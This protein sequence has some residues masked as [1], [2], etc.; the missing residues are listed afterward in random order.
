[1]ASSV[2]ENLIGLWWLLDI[3][4]WNSLLKMAVAPWKV[5]ASYLI[6]KVEK[7]PRKTPGHDCSKHD[8]NRLTH[9]LVSTNPDQDKFNRL[10]A[11]GLDDLIDFVIRRCCREDQ[12][13]MTE[14]QKHAKAEFIREFSSDTT[15]FSQD[16]LVYLMGLLDTIFFAGSLTQ[17]RGGLVEFEMLRYDPWAWHQVEWRLQKPNL[18]AYSDFPSPLSKK[19]LIAM[20]RVS[21]GRHFTRMQMMTILSHEMIH[22]F[23]ALYWDWCPG[24]GRVYVSD[25]VNSH[26]EAF[27]AMCSEINSTID[28]WHP[29]LIDIRDHQKDSGYY[30]ESDPLAYG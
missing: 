16:Q 17:R 26:G 10:H 3:V 9:E 5:L 11:Y 13:K 18:L 24:E 20:G 12:T 22:C 4:I 6:K 30:T 7:R 28:E 1:M 19:T 29:D 23:I 2:L 27:V 25:T 21:G 15:D 8:Q 14:T